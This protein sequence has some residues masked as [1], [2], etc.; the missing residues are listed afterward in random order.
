MKRYQYPQRGLTLFEVSIALS[1][2][3]AA[4]LSFTSFYLK[5]MERGLI[6]QTV[7]R[8]KLVYEGALAYRIDKKQWP[9]DIDVLIDKSYIPE[10]AAETSWGEDISFSETT[11]FTSLNM[12][13]DVPSEPIGHS[14]AAR[15]PTAQSLTTA[16]VTE[17]TEFIAIPGQEFSLALLQDLAG[18]RPWT[19]HHEAGGNDLTDVHTL[20]AKFIVTD[21]VQLGESCSASEGEEDRD[22]PGKGARAIAEHDGVSVPVLCN[23]TEWV[24][25]NKLEIMTCQVCVACSDGEDDGDWRAVACDKP[26]ND[27]W[28]VSHERHCLG[29]GYLAVKFVCGSDLT[30]GKFPDVEGVKTPSGRHRYFHTDKIRINPKKDKDVSFE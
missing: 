29:G 17:V 30:A 11:G 22:K 18:D 9:D 5:I 24:R 25:E 4:M 7:Y 12:K 16:G 10:L 28:A 15:L 3:I 1:V 21:E 13:F 14:I 19:G 8:A 23:G 26:D 2:A 20:K 27:G 6:E